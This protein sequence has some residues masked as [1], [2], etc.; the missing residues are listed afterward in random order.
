VI[1]GDLSDEEWPEWLKERAP[2]GVRV[3]SGRLS[4]AS[5]SGRTQSE[6]SDATTGEPAS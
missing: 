1:N 2:E 3:R 6:D 5:G 4:V